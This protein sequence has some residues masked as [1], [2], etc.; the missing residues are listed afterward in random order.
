MNHGHADVHSEK[1]SS[2]VLFI[3][4]RSSLIAWKGA[5]DAEGVTPIT[6]TEGDQRE[7]SVYVTFPECTALRFHFDVTSQLL[8]KPVFL[9][10]KSHLVVLYLKYSV[11]CSNVHQIL[12]TVTQHCFLACFF[13]F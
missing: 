7:Q 5:G 9:K 11:C 3:K 13:F 8:R 1:R 4:D 12:R 2:F 6:L 10:T